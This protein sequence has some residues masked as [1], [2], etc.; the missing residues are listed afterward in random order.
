MKL[1]IKNL[2]ILA[3]ISVIVTLTSCALFPRDGLP[4]QTAKPLEILEP[5]LITQA[6]Q[7]E[8][9]WWTAFGDQ[10]LNQLVDLGLRQSPSLDIAGARIV[11]AQAMLETEKA[12]FLPQVGVGGQVDRQQISQNYI[13]VP[14]MPIYTGYGLVNASLNW[15]LDI[16]GKQKKY[17]DAAKNQAK[18]AQA[19]YKASELLL[20][21]A[22]VRVYFDYDRVTQAQ[23]LYTRDAEVKKSLYQIAQEKQKAGL[24]DAFM[25]NQRKVDYES[26]QVNLSQAILSKQ[27]IQHQLAA[28]VQEGPSWGE[29]LQSP[30]IKLAGLN[31]PEVIPAN[32]LERRPDLQ[33][34]LSQIDVAKLQLEGAKLEYLPDINLAGFVGVQSFGLSQLFAS[35]SQQFSI[36]PAISLPIFD[37]G[38]INANITGKEA[39]RNQA[40]ANYQEQ[41]VQALREVADGIGTMQSSQANYASYSNAYQSAKTNYEI[42]QSRSDAG[43]SSKESLLTIEQAYI[44]QGQN[45]AEAK[46][47]M[48]T[49]NVILVQALGGSYLQTPS[50]SH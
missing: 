9:Q 8:D 41:L 46:A 33:A 28:L 40:I 6:P 18:A 32:L 11:A 19:S 23:V 45:I 35:R 14:G 43:V 22:I 7:I 10:Q 16:W 39:N 26:V 37:G 3:P 31:L 2:S 36:G 50:Q 38:L 25:I 4:E 13:F 47:K 44:A 30:A 27:M 48:L 1:S 34:L 20:S 17:Y 49:A 42:T 24:A 29:R 5:N 12:A 21:T 15:S